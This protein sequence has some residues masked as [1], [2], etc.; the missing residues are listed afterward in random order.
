MCNRFSNPSKSYENFIK[1]AVK[2]FFNKAPG[3]LKQNWLTSSKSF[4]CI[5]F[6]HRNTIY[7]TFYI[8][9]TLFCPLLSLVVLYYF[10]RYYKLLTQPRFRTSISQSG[11][12]WLSTFLHNLLSRLSIK[13]CLVIYT[14]SSNL[15][16]S[17]YQD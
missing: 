13:S 14:F 7:R 10:A 1:F 15:P 16:W 9:R 5:N 8:F 2:I 11:L 3:I 6:I 12:F 4:F 17:C